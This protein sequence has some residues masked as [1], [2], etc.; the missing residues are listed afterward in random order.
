MDT[1]LISAHLGSFVTSSNHVA[2]QDGVTDLLVA[3]EF[4]Q[5]TLIGINS[6]SFEVIDGEGSQRMVEEIILDELLSEQRR[7]RSGAIGV[8]ISLCLS[9]G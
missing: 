5:V 1:H 2:Q 3:H 6:S 8:V 9:P 7:M 4:E